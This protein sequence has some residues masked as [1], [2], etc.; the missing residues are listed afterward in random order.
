[1]GRTKLSQMQK[2]LRKC[3]ACWRGWHVYCT[4]NWEQ[5]DIHTG[6]Y[7]VVVCACWWK[8]PSGHREKER[9]TQDYAQRY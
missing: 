2:I 6:G 1:M 9:R 7:R 4:P 5:P 8:D 3:S